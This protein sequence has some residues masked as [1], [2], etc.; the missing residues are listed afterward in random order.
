M[1]SPSEPIEQEQSSR[2]L[3]RLEHDHDVMARVPQ[4]SNSLRAYMEGITL[5]SGDRRETKHLILSVSLQLV[6]QLEEH[7]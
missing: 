3:M 2:E 1:L 5:C 4:V 6:S 7:S